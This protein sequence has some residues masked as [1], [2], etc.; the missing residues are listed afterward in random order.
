MKSNIL[1]IAFFS[2]LASEASAAQFSAACRGGKV[3]TVPNGA[4]IQYRK[5]GKIEVVYSAGAPVSKMSSCGVRGKNGVVTFFRING[6][7][8]GY[9]SPDCHNVGSG[10]EYSVPGG[11]VEYISPYKSGVQ[12]KFASGSQ[13]YHSPDCKQLGV[14]R[15]F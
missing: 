1:L 2:M 6:S 10:I 9:F 7:D 5:K 3:E 8:V 4:V 13:I 14:D 15:P 12:T 11:I